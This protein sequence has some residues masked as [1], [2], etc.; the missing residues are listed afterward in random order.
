[1]AELLRKIWKKK[2]MMIVSNLFFTAIFLE[3]TIDL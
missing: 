2:M 1:V 3:S